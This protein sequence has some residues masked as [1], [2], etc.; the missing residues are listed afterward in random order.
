MT[1]TRIF[2][3]QEIQD[4]TDRVF[5]LKQHIEA[6]KLRI[7]EEHWPDFRHSYESIRLD[8]TGLVCPETVDGRIRALTLA[9]LAARQREEIK[10]RVSLAEIQD[11]YFRFLFRNFGQLYEHMSRAKVSPA[12]AGEAAARDPATIRA[13]YSGLPDVVA[14]LTEFW[15]AAAPSGTLQLQDGRQLKATFA[16]D[17]FPGHWE[18]VVSTAGL[19]IDTIVLPCPIMR[20]ASLA[21]VLPR[22]AFTEKFIKHVLTAMSYRPIATADVATPVVVIL[23]CTDDFDAASRQRSVDAAAPMTLRHT[24]RIF[25][26]QFDSF[27]EFGDFCGRLA[28]PDQVIAAVKASERMVFNADWGQTPREQL[29]RLMADDLPL[30]PQFDRRHAGHHVFCHLLG[31]MPQALAA[32]DAAEQFG[33]TPMLTAE[34]SW[35]HYSWL[36]DY[37]AQKIGRGDQQTSAHVVRALTSESAGSLVWLG[38]VPP[39]TV[40]EIRQKGQAEEIR[41]ILGKGI[42]ELV[43][44]DPQDY[45]MTSER[46]VRNLARAFLD[47]EKA[48]KEAKRKKL[49]LYGIDVPSCLA[50]GGIAVAAAFTQSATLGAVS[51]VL[52]IAGAPNLKEIKTKYVALAAEEAAR[53]ASPTGILFRHL[54]S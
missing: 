34:T 28:E 11:W 53:K 3:P 23:P 13:L 45:S 22:P 52:G 18:N 54:G 4:L 42:Q 1:S 6:G 9:L 21:D 17:V 51:G 38:N 8:A 37:Q 49:R 48:L 7:P 19:Y 43:H 41:A 24:G 40:M 26:T 44:L 14:A 29:M 36:L 12:V 31:R 15:Q 25:G 35:L 39:Q 16:G 46:V 30:P 33:G 32:Q 10:V 27:D 20:I 47:H 50:V 5:L 2:T